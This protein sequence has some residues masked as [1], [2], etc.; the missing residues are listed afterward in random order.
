[1]PKRAHV[2][3]FR[4]PM[5]PRDWKIEFRH[6]GPAGRGTLGYALYVDNV[7]VIAP[8]DALT[9]STAQPSF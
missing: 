5:E 7:L 2:V 9:P 8:Y 1:M 3:T 4:D 6:T